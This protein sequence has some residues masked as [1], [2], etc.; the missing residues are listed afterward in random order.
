MTAI[1]TEDVISTL[2]QL[3]LI[4]YW[5]GQ[6]I[7]SVTPKIIEQH[8]KNMEKRT[9]RIDPDAIHWTPYSAG[10]PS[11]KKRKISLD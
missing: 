1:K 9:V 10:P 5:K 3:N 4:K 11:P 6:H 2:Q 8:M 7:I